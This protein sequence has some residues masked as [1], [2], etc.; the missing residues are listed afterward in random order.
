MI[1]LVAVDMDG[2]FLRAD[3]SY[4]EA[5]FAEIFAEMFK[6]RMHFVVASGNQYFHLKASFPNYPDLIYIAEN[7]AYIRDA[8]QIYQKAMFTKDQL[9]HMLDVLNGFPTCKVLLSG[10][11]SAYV[12]ADNDQAFI[13]DRH[14][15]YDR[16]ATVESFDDVTDEILKIGITCPDDET[17]AIVDALKQPLAGVAQPTSSGHGDIDLLHPGIHKV[18]ALASLGNW[19]HV[20]LEE[21]TAFGDGGNDIEM[22][23]AVG[24]GVAMQNATPAVKAIA[25]DQ[26][27]VDNE[28]QGVLNYLEQLLH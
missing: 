17:E 11:A 10:V 2:T 28:H 14:F 24:L 25:S 12:L 18:A 23:K 20:D 4:D 9:T 6:R 22:L 19:L 3:Q 1:K 26:T 13:D 21:M 8:H 27:D 5:R 16:L 15:Y 7:G